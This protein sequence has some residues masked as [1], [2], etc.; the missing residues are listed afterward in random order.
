MDELSRFFPQGVKCD[1]PYDSSRFVEISITQVVETLVEAV[2]LVFLVMFLFLQ[3]FRYTLIPTL[4]V[5]VALLGTFARAARARLLDQ[6]ADHV[7]HGAGDRHRGRR[8]DRGGRE[9][10]AH[11]ERGRPAAARGHA[12]GDGPD[13]RRASSASRWC[14]SSVFVP[15]AFFGGSVGNIYRQFSLVMVGLDRCS[16]RSWRCRSRRRCAPRCSSRSR[17]ATTTRSAASSAGST[18]ASR[19]PPSGYEGCVARILQA[20]GALPGR[21][22]R[23]IVGAGGADVSCGCRRR[24]CRRKTR[25]T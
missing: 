14:W 4:V 17:P 3:N 11:H 6:R 8:R 1:I 21:S 18:A 20:R 23:L 25:A 15:L 19:A 9:R 16:R 13:L 24:S 7:R 5:P 22:T 12:Q 10:R 2:V